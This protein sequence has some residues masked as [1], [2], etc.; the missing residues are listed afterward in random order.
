[1]EL[2]Q[3]LFVLSAKLGFLTLFYRLKRSDPVLKEQLLP[4]IELVRMGLVPFTD[5]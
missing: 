2:G 3:Q 1:M 5:R 4:R